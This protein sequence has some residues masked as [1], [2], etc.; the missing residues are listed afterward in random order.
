MGRGIA[1]RRT[2]SIANASAGHKLG[3]LIGDWFEEYFV[4]PLLTSV[5]DGLRLYLDHRFRDR[6]ARGEKILWSDEEGNSVDYD[7]VMELGRLG[8]R[9]G[10]A[11]GVF[12]VLLAARLAA[13]Q[14]QGS[15]RQR[16][17]C[18]HEP[19]A[20]HGAISGH[21]GCRRFHATGPAVGA[22]ARNR[23]V[24]RAERQSDCRIFGRW[25]CKWII[26]TG[27]PKRKNNAW[28][29][30]LRRQLTD[31]AKRKAAD[32][33]RALLGKPAINTYLDRVRAALGATPQEIRFLARHDSAPRVFETIPEATA[34]LKKPDFDFANP[35]ETILVSNHLLQRR[36]IRAA[37]RFA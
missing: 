23:L 20:S 28:R 18:A 31:K 27:L 19:G 26:P 9:D 1:W 34:F 24:L 17:A 22:V 3:Q 36:G 35:T 10:G 11:R 37:S 5:A 29:G 12:R 6:P 30:S 13:F 21:Y 8:R 2:N 4:L 32:K 7:F 15:R 33:L 14:G 16:Q 25:K